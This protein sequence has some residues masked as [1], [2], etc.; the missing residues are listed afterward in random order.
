MVRI[1]VGMTRRTMPTLP[2]CWKTFTRKRPE[3]GDAVGHIQ[4]GG[5]LEF[6]LLPVGHHAEGHGKHL[7]RRYARNVVERVQRAV[8]AKI[9][10]IAD[11]Q[12][13]VG[14]ALV[15]GATEKVV[16]IDGHSSTFLV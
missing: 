2:R 14:R 1:L 9:R 10:V 6:L 4:L 15:Y 13:Q 12:V 3:A 8:D 5:L 16:N 7:F 11:L